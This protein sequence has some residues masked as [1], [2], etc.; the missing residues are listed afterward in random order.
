MCKDVEHLRTTA[1]QLKQGSSVMANQD[2]S[3]KCMGRKT[4]QQP[5]LII[6]AYLVT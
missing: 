6:V 4:Q 3:V 2:Y 1:L 5:V